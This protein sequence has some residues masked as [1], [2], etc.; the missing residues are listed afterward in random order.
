MNLNWYGMRQTWCLS[1]NIRLLCNHWGNYRTELKFKMRFRWSFSFTFHANNGKAFPLLTSCLEERKGFPSIYIYTHK[2]SL[3]KEKDFPPYIY[4]LT[5]CPWG[6]RKISLHIYIYTHKLSLRKEKDF[7]PYI[8]TH[9]LSLRKEKDFPSI[10][11]Y[12]QVV[13]EERERF[14]SIYIYTHKLSL[15]KEKD[16]PPYIYTLTSCPWGKKRIS[17][18]IYTLTSC[19]W[20]PG[21]R[22]WRSLGCCPASA[23]GWAQPTL[24]PKLRHIRH[25]TSLKNVLV[26]I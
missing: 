22:S 8:Y 2:L 13:L 19:P 15:R 20:D 1:N 10:Y 23:P 6:K 26:F 14:S 18:H 9:K 17:L 5:S 4:T 11:I 12:S 7:P 21:R 24:Q 25:G 16:F 3:R